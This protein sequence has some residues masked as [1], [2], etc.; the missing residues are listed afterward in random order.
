[1]KNRG[2]NPP[3][4]LTY[5]AVSKKNAFEPEFRLLLALLGE[6]LGTVGIDVCKRRLNDV[7]IDWK[8]FESLLIEHRVVSIV[9]DG[10]MRLKV[11]SG[12]SADFG[13]RISCLNRSLQLRQLGKTQELLE[14]VRAFESHE[15][16]FL[17]LK[18]PAVSQWLYGDAAKRHC[19][20]LDVLVLQD[21][22]HKV[23]GAMET[24]GYRRSGEAFDDRVRSGESF[25]LLSHHEHYERRGSQ[26]EVHWRLSSLDFMFLDSIS[27]LYDRRV[28]VEIGGQSVPMLGEEDLVDYL[29]LHGTAHSWHRLKWLYDIARARQLIDPRSR[30]DGLRRAVAMRDQLMETLLPGLSDG[31]KSRATRSGWLSRWLARICLSQ[32]VED[33]LGADSPKKVLGRTLAVFLC[34]V[35]VEEK[36]R[37]I[38]TLFSWPQFYER[39]PLPPR[40]RYLYCILGPFY[41]IYRKV[42]VRFLS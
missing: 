37:Y 24:L 40:L 13:Q 12:F 29:T 39:F 11:E 28:S 27:E 4:T 31:S 14:I 10:L 16:R 33:G 42:A 38:Y 35:G 20:D 1:M 3:P 41:W 18:G 36:L 5:L 7:S 15:I 9:Y 25:Q 8:W 21:D 30:Q 19:N 17:T 34:A 32:I 6:N 23:S 2:I 22:F 26:V